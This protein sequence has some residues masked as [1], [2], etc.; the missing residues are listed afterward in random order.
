MKQYIPLASIG[1]QRRGWLGANMT[2]DTKHKSELEF[3]GALNTQEGPNMCGM[4][5]YF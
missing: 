3:V 2:K 4:C 5:L 1:Q